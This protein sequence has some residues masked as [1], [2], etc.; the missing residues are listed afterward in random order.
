MA[1]LDFIFGKSEKK[2][3][4][5]RFTPDQENFLN[6]L[7]SQSQQITP[8]AFS[9]LSSILGESP[10]AF[11]QFEAPIKRQFEEE[12]LPSIAERFTGMLG[13]GS[14]RSSAFGQQLGKAGERLS[15]K[16]AAQRAGLK[17]QALAQL[18][19]LS[20]T[21]LTPRFETLVRPRQPGALE[22]GFRGIFQ[23]LPQLALLGGY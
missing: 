17:N 2:E 15:E 13:E 16:L 11:A 6:Q 22:E 18:M 21:G 4:L 1:F 5:P 7:L 20:Q 19:G 14:S 8:D 12:V 9:Y 3:Q 10:E 23:N